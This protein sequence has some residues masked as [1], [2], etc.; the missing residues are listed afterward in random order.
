MVNRFVVFNVSLEECREKT[1][2][3]TIFTIAGQ[4]G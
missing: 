1:T 3:F 2:T 4:V